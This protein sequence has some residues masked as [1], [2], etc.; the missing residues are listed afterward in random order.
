MSL[1]V[2]KSQFDFG[3]KQFVSHTSFNDGGKQNPIAIDA[4]PLLLKETD[5]R[6]VQDVCTISVLPDEGNT[7]PQYAYKSCLVDINVD[8]GSGETV[9][10]HDGIG[11]KSENVSQV[12]SLT[13]YAKG[14]SVSETERCH[15]APTNRWRK[16]KRA[17]SFDSRKIVILFSILSSVGTLILIYLTLRVKQN[18]DDNKIS[19]NEAER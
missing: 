1:S 15:D 10:P 4:F 19:E 14:K 6:I 3:K 7:S 17:A 5:D 11:V 18:G 13:A 9:T 16:Y 8:K 12:F 2:T